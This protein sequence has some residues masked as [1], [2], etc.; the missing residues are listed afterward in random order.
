MQ[1]SHHDSCLKI[2]ERREYSP[3]VVSRMQN[4][5]DFDYSMHRKDL[6]SRL[7]KKLAILRSNKKGGLISIIGDP[8]MGKTHYF[9][10]IN[11]TK[12]T[13]SHLIGVQHLTRS[14]NFYY[15]L[16]L[17]FL[18]TGGFQ[19]LKKA[20][21]SMFES[22]GGSCY[23][24]DPFGLILIRHNKQLLIERL[25]NKYPDVPQSLLE[26]FVKLKVGST[27]ERMLVRRWLLGEKLRSSQLKEIG[28][29]DC[30]ISPETILEVLKFI[31]A[32]IEQ[33]FE[34]YLDELEMN[35]LSSERWG[36]F[37]EFI[38]SL[39]D[40]L[41]G[42]IIFLAIA[43][44]DWDEFLSHVTADLKS[45]VKFQLFLP[46]L[47][48]P[49]VRAIYSKILA[50]YW[51]ESDKIVSDRAVLRILQKSN[52]VPRQVLKN[53]HSEIQAMLESSIKK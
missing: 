50:S 28:I 31:H 40:K 1:T 45:Q 30:M 3:S 24:I 8:G 15:H 18:R 48:I 39:L 32:N 16:Y 42:S 37:L 2:I 44:R 35:A 23:A 53:I 19:L 20:L 27:R 5:D 36:E 6:D 22:V 9:W 11:R 47:S 51:Q 4:P 49:D 34:I 46:T 43:R 38:N 26:S 10:V 14:R 12:P 21:N 25:T 13:T 33:N 17:D 41:P 52:G 29:S 7:M